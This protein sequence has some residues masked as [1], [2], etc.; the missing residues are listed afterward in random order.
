MTAESPCGT[1]R[2]YFLDHRHDERHRAVRRTTSPGFRQ[3]ARFPGTGRVQSTR[4][5]DPV[6]QQ[7]LPLVVV[8]CASRGTG[9]AARRDGAFRTV[10]GDPRI[11]TAIQLWRARPFTAAIARAQR[12]P[13][14]GHRSAAR[15]FRFR[16][17]EAV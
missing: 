14:Q 2:L 16:I 4:T 11:V 1:R 5:C 17:P 9:A 13:A 6:A 8:G 12:P 15:G 3:V 7:G 10:D